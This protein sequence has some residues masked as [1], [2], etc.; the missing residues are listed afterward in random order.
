MEKNQSNESVSQYVNYIVSKYIAVDTPIRKTIPV[1]YNDISKSKDDYQ[2]EK[3]IL[4][5]M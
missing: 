3:D 1:E 2:N 5:T 4:Q